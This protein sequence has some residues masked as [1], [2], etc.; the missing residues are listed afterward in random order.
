MRG[1]PVISAATFAARPGGNSRAQDVVDAFAFAETNRVAVLVRSGDDQHEFAAL[2]I[3]IAFDARA[4]FRQRAVQHRFVH[5]GQFAR[6]DG[7]PF[8][9]HLRRIAQRV[10]DAMRL[11]S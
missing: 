8:A 10:D 5:L 9:Q 2:L 4:Q 3:R 7:L 11:D 6:D 1:A